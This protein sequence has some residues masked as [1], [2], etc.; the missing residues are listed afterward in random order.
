MDRKSFELIEQIKK[1]RDEAKE[2]FL[3]NVENSKQQMIKRSGR[4]VLKFIE[5]LQSGKMELRVYPRLRSFK[6]YIIRKDQDKSPDYYGS[7]ITG[8]SNFSLNGMVENLE[9]NVEL[10]VRLMK[11][12]AHSK[13]SKNSGS[14]E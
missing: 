14:M 13:D 4:G 6:V 5:F 2:D 12:I 7:V 1:S 3:Y 8:S 9:F 11:I 10:K